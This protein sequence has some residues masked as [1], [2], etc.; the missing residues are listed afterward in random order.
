VQAESGGNYSVVVSSSGGSVTSSNA[1]LTIVP[2]IT[3]EPQSR[4]VNRGSNVTFTVVAAGS[5]TLS[6]Q[7]R[8]NGVNLGNATSSSFT[9]NNVQVASAGNYS[10]VVSNLGG[11]VTSSNAL[12][13][14]VPYITTEP[15]SRTVNRGS[16][17]TFTVVAAGSGTLSYQ[18]RFNGVNL[19]NAT[20]SS[21]T[22]NNVQVAS[23][24]NYSVVV[25]NLGGSVTSSNALLT[26]V[27]YITTEPQSR[28]VNRGS[29]VTFTVVAAGSGTLS[30]QWRFNGGSIANATSASFTTNNVQVASGGNY[31]VVVSNSGGSVTSSNAL[32]TIVP[33]IT[34]QPAGAWAFTGGS[35]TFDV[36][37]E[38]TPTLY[39]Q[40]MFNG[41][42]IAG[43]TGSS[44][45]RTNL[46]TD[47][48]GNYS[49]RVWNTGGSVTS[50]NAALDVYDTSDPDYDGVP[51]WYE[52]EVD[53][54]PND[55]SSFPAMILGRF[56]FDDA[57]VFPGEQGQI[58]IQNSGTFGTNGIVDGAAQ[59]GG[60]ANPR[61]AY[62]VKQEDGYDNLNCR[63]GSVRFWFRPSWSSQSAG[64]FGPGS[65]ARLIEVGNYDP[66]FA[67]ACWAITI[68]ASGDAL[69]FVCGSDGS[70]V[71]L[72]TPISWREG[73]WHQVVVT[74]GNYQCKLYIDLVH[75]ATT[76][77]ITG[78]PS[79]AVRQASGLR[80]GSDGLGNNCAHGAFDMLETFNYEM[81]A[82]DVD[83]GVEAVQL[84]FAG[85]IRVCG[86]LIGPWSGLV[87]PTISFHFRVPEP[88]TQ[89]ESVH[90]PGGVAVDPGVAYRTLVPLNGCYH[91]PAVQY[92]RWKL[93]GNPTLSWD[94]AMGNPQAGALT[95]APGAYDIA[96][97]ANSTGPL[98]IS[99]SGTAGGLSPD[100]KAMPSKQIIG[101]WSLGSAAMQEITIMA[102]PEK[103]LGLWEFDNGLQGD[104]GQVPVAGVVS[105]QNS[106][107]GHAAG[108]G[109][110][111]PKQLTYDAFGSDRG[112]YLGDVAKGTGTPN[113]RRNK[114]TIRFWFRPNWSSG[115]G[116]AQGTLIDLG[117]LGW[118]LQVH[119]DGT[120]LRLASRSGAT[121]SVAFNKQISWVEATWYAIAV[122]Y[123]EVGSALYVNGEPVWFIEDP[124]SYIGAPVLTLDNF[125]RLNGSFLD[126]GSQTGSTRCNGVIDHVET[127]N[128]VLPKE[129]IKGDYEAQLTN[130]PDSDGDGWKDARE[131]TEHTNPFDPDTDGD[132]VNDPQDPDPLNSNIWTQ[133]DPPH[134]T[135]PSI[136]LTEPVGATR[137]S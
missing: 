122:T 77:G 48:D 7:W 117:S 134:S 18:W 103:R 35:A 58:P 15:Q 70:G 12:L 24:G 56:R 28:I 43:A 86:A 95:Q 40:W 68:S 60:S 39:Y 72:Q 127:F 83:Q 96:F 91:D 114:G 21:F 14:I 94:Y 4:T 41:T 74:Y 37:A 49:V 13:T 22:T 17:V 25:S 85:A 108:F 121:E 118:T 53:T 50:T 101:T 31:S 113:V 47:S 89:G 42:N 119:T 120:M 10:V 93:A 29:N 67:N 62:S 55:G 131:I 97:Q 38:G 129:T 57:T 69:E 75:C 100:G 107:F 80:I 19:G 61:L 6:Y 88:V 110:P 87:D 102:L 8:F 98:L 2:Y 16:N 123:S 92:C 23:A 54:L 73:E 65:T 3:T 76:G 78:Y 112:F 34:T 128:C 81:A 9:T 63:R 126:I 30:Y 64:G 32:L 66:V 26:I 33:Y 132:G 137:Q 111:A 46:Q 133:P 125:E 20:S 106:L 82:E 11:S 45:T 51:T 44:Y 130:G 71:V 27:P 116:P 84:Q 109:D 59:I 36:V 1:L 124:E 136:I 90:V 5:G 52:L 79:A 115:S 99:A 105:M 135:P 104:G